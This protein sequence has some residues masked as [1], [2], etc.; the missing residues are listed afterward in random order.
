MRPLLQLSQGVRNELSGGKYVSHAIL[1]HLV[2]V[3]LGILTLFRY[4][5][6]GFLPSGCI[7]ALWSTQPR[8]EMSTN[9]AW[10]VLKA[11]NLTAICEQNV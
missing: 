2:V 1:A 5:F 7:V 6:N 4:T 9:R 10:P 3:F 8:M 11:D